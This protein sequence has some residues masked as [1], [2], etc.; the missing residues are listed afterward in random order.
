[1]ML[2]KNSENLS[3]D[4][5]LQKRTVSLDLQ[6]LANDRLINLFVS[7]KKVLSFRSLVSDL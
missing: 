1:M 7:K 4:G 2:K 3:A 5:L 6:R